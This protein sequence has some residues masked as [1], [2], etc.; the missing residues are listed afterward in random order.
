MPTTN[1]SGAF[2]ETDF[3]EDLKS[4]TVPTLVAHGDDDQVVPIR[5]FGAVG[6]EAASRM[7]P[8]KCI[9]ACAH[10]ACASDAPGHHQPRSAS[11]FIAQLTHGVRCF[12][13][14]RYKQRRA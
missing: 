1:A 10:G 9:Q 14:R 3:T 6:S 7:P 13:N 4:I 11:V 2:S 5:R 12:R 8:S